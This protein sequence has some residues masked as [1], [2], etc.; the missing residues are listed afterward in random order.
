[1]QVCEIDR[2]ERGGP[3]LAG[4]LPRPVGQLELAA[5][6][7]EVVLEEER[8]AQ[9]LVG[10]R[11]TSRRN[12]PVQVLESARIIARGQRELSRPDQR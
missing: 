12:R 11:I 4:V 7:D 10:E 8:T 1:M 3:A 2:D 9:D 6:T 5:G